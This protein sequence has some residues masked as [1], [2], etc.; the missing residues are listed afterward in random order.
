MYYEERVIDGKLMCRGTPDGEWREI[1]YEMIS[2][3]LIQA[4]AAFKALDHRCKVLSERHDGPNGEQVPMHEIEWVI[5]SCLDENLMQLHAHKAKV[6]RIKEWLR[7][8]RTHA[9]G[10]GQS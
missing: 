9:T 10:G 2:Q 7:T 6:E 3:R 4:E 1:D 5:R 8:E